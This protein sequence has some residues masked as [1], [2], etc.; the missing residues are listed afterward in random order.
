[1]VAN[2]NVQVP[3]AMTNPTL[4]GQPPCFGQ[5]PETSTI[6]VQPKEKV[7]AR[8]TVQPTTET[9]GT[10]VGPCVYAS[11]IGP[12]VGNPSIDEP[13][14]DLADDTK[15]ANNLIRSFNERFGSQVKEPSL[16]RDPY[17]G[18]GHRVLERTQHPRDHG[19]I[20]RLGGPIVS[21]TRPSYQPNDGQVLPE[22]SY[23]RTD[24]FQSLLKD[25]EGG[26]HPTN[27]RPEQNGPHVREIF[28]R[29]H[30][31]YSFTREFYTQF[32]S[33]K[34]TPYRLEDL[35]E[36]IQRSEEP[37]KDYL[38]RFMAE[39]TKVKNLMEEERKKALSSLNKI[40]DKPKV[41]D[42]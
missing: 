38:Q 30:S 20:S 3:P 4:T 26:R 8:P 1:M 28:R 39:A 23:A 29:F 2:S 41:G 5:L 11:E 9:L 19:Q 18:K 37:L 21:Q 13:H 12:G 10:R 6:E 25:E 34:Q 15:L 24:Q 22:R 35:V 32:S 36:V 42:K 27:T 33:S 40:S 16:V 14:M 17:K 31:W 7:F